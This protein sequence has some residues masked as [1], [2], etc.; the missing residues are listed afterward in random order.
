[1]FLSCGL[2]LEVTMES[3]KIPS[4][5]AKHALLPVHDINNDENDEENL[6]NPTEFRDHQHA[7]T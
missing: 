7:T 4:D 5:D 2:L 1:M 6:F 3:E